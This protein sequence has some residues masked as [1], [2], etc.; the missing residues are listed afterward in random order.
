MKSLKLLLS[1]LLLVTLLISCKKEATDPRPQFV[2]TWTGTISLVVPGLNSNTSKAESVTISTGTGNSNQIIIMQAGST[3]TMTAVVNGNSYK[4]D[5]YTLSSSIGDISVSIKFNGTGTL[6][7]GVI[8][9]TGTITYT[10]AGVAY[11]GTWSS[12]LNKQ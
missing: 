9:E 11:P 12:T 3:I 1:T 2:G 7:G 10:L 8:S 4:Y 5:E 6:T